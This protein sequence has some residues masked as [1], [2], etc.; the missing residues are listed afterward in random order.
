MT[1][2]RLSVHLLTVLLFLSVLRVPGSLAM[3]E[4]TP[5][6]SPVADTIEHGALLPQMDLSVHPGKDF[7]RY[8]TGGW[9]D[10]TEIP[11]LLTQSGTLFEEKVERTVAAG[12]RTINLALPGADGLD[13][14]DSRPTDNERVVAETRALAAG[15]TL[16]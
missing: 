16:V 8:A 12:F 14:Q 6:A 9:Q 11:P 2:R 3:Q 1:K 4:A 10:R 15:E 7:F 5:I 13:A